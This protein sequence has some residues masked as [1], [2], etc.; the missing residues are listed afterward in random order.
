MP[1]CFWSFRCAGRAGGQLLGEYV[2]TFRALLRDE[3]VEGATE[4][5]VVA[6]GAGL[7]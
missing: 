6:F 4:K 2:V 5:Q 7:D 1:W 3:S